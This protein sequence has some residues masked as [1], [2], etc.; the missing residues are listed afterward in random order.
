MAA[1]G[2]PRTVL[3]L[4][5]VYKMA[6][7]QCTKEEIAAA[8]KVNRHT[9]YRN[10]EFSNIYEQGLAEGRVAIKIKQYDVAM[11]GDREMLKW[12]GRNYLGQAE[13]TNI[14]HTGDLGIVIVDDIGNKIKGAQ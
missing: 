14:K 6:V 11:S 12:L 2:R 10:K 9:L 5:E 4:E 13:Q 1:R 7:R 8:L 3:D